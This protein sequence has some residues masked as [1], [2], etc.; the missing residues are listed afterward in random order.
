MLPMRYDLTEVKR[1]FEQKP[2]TLA[3]WGIRTG[4]H[5]TTLSKALKRGTAS[6]KSAYLMA[7]SLGIDYRTLVIADSAS[8]EQR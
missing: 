7:D 5:Y 6:Q 8:A 3:Q 4:L 2:W 1:R